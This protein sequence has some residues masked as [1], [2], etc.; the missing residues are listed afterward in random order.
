MNLRSGKVPNTL[1]TERKKRTKGSSSMASLD[2]HRMKELLTEVTAEI[3]NELKDF[4]GDFKAFREETKHE[5]ANMRKEIGEYAAEMRAIDARVSEAEERVNHVEQRETIHVEMIKSLIQNVS[6][7]DNRVEYLE[8]KSRQMNIRL[9]NVKEDKD[10]ANMMHFVQALLHEAL[11][12]P[13]A[14]FNI[15]AAH[16]SAATRTPEVQTKPRSIIVR[17]ATWEA[18]QQVLR[19][20]WGRKEVIYRGERIYVDQDFTPRLQAQRK[21]FIRIRNFLKEKGV[22]SHV[23]YPAKL[24]VFEEQGQR[25]FNTPQDAERAYGLSPTPCVKPAEPGDWIR[26]LQ[27][28]GWDRVKN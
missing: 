2:E 4:R 12:T 19:L 3:S 28:L 16:R 14:D 24:C 11:Q 21:G 6:D 10:P 25:M 13:K 8:N 27:L 1:K 15:V 18:K 23:R 20:A 7:L 5:M 22:K 17:F 26:Q 9:Y